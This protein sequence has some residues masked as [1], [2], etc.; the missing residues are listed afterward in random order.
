MLWPRKKGDAAVRRR[1]VFVIE[2][3]AITREL[4]EHQIA[5]IDEFELHFAEDGETGLEMARLLNPGLILLDWVLPGAGGL[6]VLGK[7]KGSPATSH[8]AVYMM[9]S[10]GKIDDVEKAMYRGAGDYFIKP[11][12]LAELS[13]KVKKT[14]T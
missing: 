1:S 13:R 3:D 6:E 5:R 12:D 8:I 2:D 4:V 10:K 7:L 9:T 14:L 11:I